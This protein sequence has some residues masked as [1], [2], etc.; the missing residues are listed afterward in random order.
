M[1]AVEPARPDPTVLDP[2]LRH[3]ELETLR[4]AMVEL[5]EGLRSSLDSAR[6]FSSNAAHEL[7]TP[8]TTIVGELELLA[9][10][11]TTS[12]ARSI[13]RVRRRVADLSTL[14]ERLLILAQ[15]GRLPESA[16]RTIDLADVIDAVTESLP[17]DARARVRVDHTPD[18]LLRGDESLL[19]ALISNA[20]SNA[21]KF[22]STEVRVWTT[23]DATTARLH[24]RDRGVG[25][26]PNERTKVFEAFYRV[27]GAHLAGPGGHGVGLALIAHVARLHGGE[28][29][30][31][32]VDEGTL[33]VVD[34]PSWRPHRGGAREGGEP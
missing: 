26:A 3:A 12:D 9:E 15:P 27:Q 21:L 2:P 22:S 30:L 20:I 24:V 11:A 32:D 34:F 31:D 17:D 5:L 10:Q 8:L 29:H 25:I 6:S 23:V 33:L 4:S 7:R 16:L 18:A 13:E 19:K 14:V 28:A 1:R